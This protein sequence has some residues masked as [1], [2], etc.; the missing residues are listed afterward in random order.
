[1]RQVV[2]YGKTR[3]ENSIRSLVNTALGRKKADIVIK[4]VNLVNVNSGEILEKVDIALSLDRIALVGNAQHTIGNNTV[5]IDGTKKYAVPGFLDGHVHVE[6][7][8]VTLTQFSRAILPH[9]TTTIFMDPHEIANVLGL[10]GVKIMLKEAKNIPLKV[11]VCVPSCVPSAPDF[12]TS[13]A[14]ITVSDVKRALRW[15]NVIGLGEVMDYPGVLKCDEEIIKKIQLTLR[16]DKVVE[17]HANALLGRELSAY[18]A[19]GISS[20]HEAT[21]LIDGMQRLR[22]GLHT[23]IREGSAS[24][25]LSGVIKCVT[26]LGMD[27]RHVVLVTDDVGPERLTKLGHMDYVVRRA[28]QEGVDPLVAIQMATLNTAEH[29]GLHDLGSIA[30]G[31]IADILLL[32]DLEKI[33]TQTVIV[34]GQIVARDGQMRISL[35]T[36]KYPSYAKFSIH[37]KRRLRQED[38]RIMAPQGRERVLVRVIG[39]LEDKIITKHLQEDLDVE[40]SNINVDVKKDVA[41]VAVIERHKSTGNLGLGF[42]KGFGI[43]KGAVATSVAHD[44]HNIVTV[45]VSDTDMK[46][47]ANSL[48]TAGGGIVVVINNKVVS[49]LKL[50]IAGLM[51]DENIEGVVEQRNKLKEAWRSLGCKN[52]SLL[53]IMSFLTLPVLPELRIT[54]LGLVDTCQFKFVKLLLD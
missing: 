8:M 13:G 12:E 15:K 54:D 4:N 44:S 48:S 53:M 50:Q 28:I 47:A 45:G 20:C 25:D 51:S 6:S 7:S 49:S 33:E 16:V 46:T 30:P 39:V 5:I 42:A 14:K 37:L 34:D 32:D 11:F 18:V 21:R 1:M 40:N 41:K 36:P 17:G 3:L 43:K 24:S 22:L 9:G 27:P 52:D 38:F 35:L 23:M 2:D 29:F 26:Q 31:K 19:A 10:K